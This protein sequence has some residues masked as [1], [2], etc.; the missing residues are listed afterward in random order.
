MNRL[1]VIVVLILVPITIVTYDNEAETV[2]KGNTLENISLEIPVKNEEEPKIVIEDSK[3][4]V[5]ISNNKDK[6][7]PYTLDLEEYIIGVVAG[8]MP[9]SFNME[10]LKAQAISSRTYAMYKMKIL[11][12]YFCKKII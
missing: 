3:P 5:L 10:A 1:L 12:N 2:L 8:E 6:S 9:A 4:T 7:N 11:N